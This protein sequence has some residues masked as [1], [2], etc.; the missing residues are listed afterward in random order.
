MATNLTIERIYSYNRQ[1]NPQTQIGKRA[2]R[3]AV[4]SGE[5]PAIKVGNRRL[6]S[7]ET[8]NKWTNGEL[9]GQL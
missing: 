1:E 2:I 3:N 9:N 4:E 6:I 8:F 7:V 5:L